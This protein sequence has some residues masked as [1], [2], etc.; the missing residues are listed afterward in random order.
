LAVEEGKP[1][2]SL[3]LIVL[4]QIYASPSKVSRRRGITLDSRLN[5]PLEAQH[6][7]KKI[8]KKKKKKRFFFLWFQTSPFSQSKRSPVHVSYTTCS[9]LCLFSTLRGGVVLLVAG[10]E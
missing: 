1:P 10:P 6:S 8:L 7:L 2:I 5:V 9:S 3:S 4:T